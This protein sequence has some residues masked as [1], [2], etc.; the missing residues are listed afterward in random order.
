MDIQ[1]IR[2][3]IPEILTQLVAFLLV[4]WILKKY[5][6]GAVFKILEERRDVISSDLAAAENKK[7][8]LEGL[9][10]DY[11]RRMQKIEQES[12]AKIQEAIQD[13]QRIAGE[14]RVKAHDD[15]VTQVD[16]AK[17]EIAQEIQKAK[18]EMRRQII[19]LSTQIAEKLI[20]KNLTDAENERYVESILNQTGDIS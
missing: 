20:A 18:S 10:L 19:V 9:K 7:R 13:G 3:A 5:A 15:A 16:R 2:D 11:E 17:R 1:V 12:R 8:E 14:I 6:F 4:F